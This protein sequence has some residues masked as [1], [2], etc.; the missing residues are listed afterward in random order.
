MGVCSSN[1]KDRSR[2]DEVKYLVR[3]QLIVVVNVIVVTSA[4]E[5]DVGVDDADVAA[6]N[7]ESLHPAV[8]VHFDRGPNGKRRKRKRGDED[9]VVPVTGIDRQRREYVE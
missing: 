8:A 5:S 2:L 3:F 4:V 6:A 9:S 1:V 7:M